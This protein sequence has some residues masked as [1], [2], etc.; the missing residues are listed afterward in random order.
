A[1]SGAPDMAVGLLSFLKAGSAYVPLDPED[2]LER[3][4]YRIEDSGVGLLLSDRALFAAWGEWPEGVA[5]WCLEDDHPLLASCPTCEL[6][7]INLPQ[8]QA[9]LIY[10][11][12]STVKPKGL[13]VA[14]GE[15]AMHCQAVIRRFDM[16][17]YDCALHFSSINFDAA[18]ERLR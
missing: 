2:P 10:T 11:S 6:P 1:R 4:H 7:F 3:L 18:T 17:P 8:H 12:G 13:V 5:R 16:R 15:I 14:H 9:Y